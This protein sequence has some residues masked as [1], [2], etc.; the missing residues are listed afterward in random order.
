MI[1]S[2]TQQDAREIAAIYNYYIEH[3]AIT[4]ET[5]PLSVQEMSERI[6]TISQPYPY[7]AYETSGGEVVGYCYASPWKKR[8]AYRHTVESTVYV[9]RSAQHKG[10][11]LS[12]MQALLDALKERSVHA[13]VACIA[14]PN[15]Q[16]IG[17]HEKLGFRQASRFREVGYKQNRWIDVG[18]WELLFPEDLPAF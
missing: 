3:T 4:F 10:I 2:V 16:S 11:G 1:R 5:S 9:S 7:L 12:L 18:D 17:L 13:V 14:L 8:E 6:R 15:P